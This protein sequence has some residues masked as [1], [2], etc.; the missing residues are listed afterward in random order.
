M[1]EY[2]RQA[3]LLPSGD[4]CTPIKPSAKNT[5]GMGATSAP[6][7]PSATAPEAPERKMYFCD[8]CCKEFLTMYGLNIHRKSKHEKDF[9]HVCQIC[10][11]GF[12]QAIQYCSHCANHLNAVLEKC[13]FYDTEFRS[14]GCLKKHLN[15]CKHNPK[16]SDAA[17][18]VCAVCSPNMAWMITGAENT[19][20]QGIFAQSWLSFCMAV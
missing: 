15:V 4:F 20:P 18:Y 13:S 10:Q 17:K 5:S 1:Q 9:K 11:K 8:Q 12:N 7:G 16:R 3:A 2:T 14:P 6:L 19:S